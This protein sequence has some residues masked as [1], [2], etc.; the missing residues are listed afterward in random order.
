VKHFLNSLKEQGEQS[1]VNLSVKEQYCLAKFLDID[2]DCLIKKDFLIQELKKVYRIL[3]QGQVQAMNLLEKNDKKYHKHFEVLKRGLSISDQEEDLCGKL[4]RVLREKL[5]E[6]KKWFDSLGHFLVEEYECLEVDNHNKRIFLT[7][8]VFRMFLESKWGHKIN[9]KNIRELMKC[10]KSQQSHSLRNLDDGMFFGGSKEKVNIIELA[11]QLEVLLRFQHQSKLA[12]FKMCTFAIF[13]QSE[14]LSP[15]EY[16]S[17]N[18]VHNLNKKIEIHQFQLLNSSHLRF[19]LEDSD[20][21]FS[22]I[23]LEQRNKVKYVDFV[24]KIENIQQQIPNSQNLMKQSQ[25]LR[26]KN[27][28]N[29]TN[30]QSKFRNSKGKI[31][32]KSNSIKVY[33]TGRAHQQQSINYPK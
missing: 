15:R 21:E 18:G 10:L 33:L 26:E 30:S 3:E 12:G 25:V 29:L 2:N 23:D 6:P 14:G 7:Q 4:L 17:K 5:I 27:D 28:S 22:K 8:D 1:N 32:R 24:K 9:E 11:N 16:F 19:K 31:N 13:L 20:L